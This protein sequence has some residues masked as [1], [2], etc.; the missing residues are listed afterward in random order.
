[1]VKPLLHTNLAWDA[2]LPFSFS[3]NVQT[4]LNLLRVHP[5]EQPLIDSLLEGHFSALTL[6]AI[7]ARAGVELLGGIENRQVVDFRK[8]SNPQKR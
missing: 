8:C 1:M 4:V 3:D 2:S 6:R 5:R 7:P